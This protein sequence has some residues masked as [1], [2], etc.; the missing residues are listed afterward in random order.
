MCI[1]D[2]QESDQKDAADSSLAFP[3][4][5]QRWE[6]IKRYEEDIE[7]GDDREYGPRRR[8]HPDVGDA[9]LW[10][11]EGFG[12]VVLAGAGNTNYQGPDNNG[13]AEGYHG[14]QTN[15]NHKLK[16]RDGIEDSKI[17]G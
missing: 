16:P 7:V 4:E 12:V 9:P 1:V 8:G 17:E 10:K 14:N 5:L 15:P 6:H 13:D 11:S 2:S 3:R